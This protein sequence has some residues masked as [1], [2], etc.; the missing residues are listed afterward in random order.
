[1]PLIRYLGKKEIQ[2]DALYESGTT[3][4]GH[5]DIQR[6]SDE[7]AAK[8]LKHKDVYAQVSEDDMA[9]IASG[10]DQALSSLADVINAVAE[11]VNATLPGTASEEEEEAMRALAVAIA[12]IVESEDTG[13]EDALQSEIINAINSLDETD[14]S[15]WGTKTGKPNV[16]AIEKVLGYDITAADRDAAC[17]AID[18]AE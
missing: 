1:M 13:A 9:E 10:N 15:L 2:V 8:L 6:V 18:A 7:I 17:A 12:V 4:I 16:K 3:W 11:R 5:G 14:T